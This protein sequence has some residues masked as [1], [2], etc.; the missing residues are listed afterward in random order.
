MRL[1]PLGTSVINW[2]IVPAP[3]DDDND[4]E[5]GAVG[6]MRIGSGNWSTRIKP[7]P[8]PLWPQIPHDVTWART[9]AAALGSRRL[10]VWDMA[11]PASCLTNVSSSFLGVKWPECDAK[12]F[13]PA[14]AAFYAP[15]YEFMAWIIYMWVTFFVL[16]LHFWNPCWQEPFIGLYYSPLFFSAA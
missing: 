3:D 7:T 2:P 12:N 13:P 11:R 1:N 9:R 15:P 8:M 4:D 14:T 10:T 6:G 5:C 16:T